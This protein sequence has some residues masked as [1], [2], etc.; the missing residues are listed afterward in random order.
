MNTKK[1]IKKYPIDLRGKGKLLFNLNEFKKKNIGL[2]DFYYWKD[3]E[4]YK[5]RVSQEILSIKENHFRDL[6]ECS[7]AY[8]RI[9]NWMWV[10]ATLNRLEKEIKQI[11]KELKTI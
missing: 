10:G 2:T 4:E 9:H 1:E 8:K 6:D 11:K 3:V 5:K 7:K